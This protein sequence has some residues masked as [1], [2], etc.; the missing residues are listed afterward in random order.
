MT[1]ALFDYLPKDAIL[2]AFA[3][4][5]GNELASGKLES[6]ESSA[7]LAANTFGLFLTGIPHVELSRQLERDAKPSLRQG[8]DLLRGTI[9]T[10]PFDAA[11][12]GALASETGHWAGF[13]AHRSR[14][15]RRMSGISSVMSGCA[16]V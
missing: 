16:P 7:A 9:G 8:A 4:S 2:A 6:P 13:Q 15:L 1:D 5:P 14:R 11:K 12:F 3:R 10:V